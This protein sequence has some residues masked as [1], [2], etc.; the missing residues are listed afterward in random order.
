LEPLFRA[1]LGGSLPARIEFWDGSALG[2]ADA[3]GRARFHSV[4]GI[5][6]IL[7]SPDELG[8]GRAVVVGDVD[9]EG[10]LFA[11]LDTLEALNLEDIRIGPRTLSAAVAAA[12]R[13]GALGWPPAPPPEETRARG[14]RHS[15]A[16]DSRAV[17]HH[18]DVGNDFYRLVLGPSLT[19]SCARYVTEDMT[20][21]QAQSA[22]HEL[23]CA[24]LG[25][26][27]RPGMRL[28]DVGCGWGSMALHA[29]THH[30]ATVVGLTLSE[31]QAELARDRVAERNLTDRVDIRV[32]DYRDLGDEA[33]DAI[34]SIG[35]FE[36][37]GNRNADQYFRILRAR[38][39]PKGRFLNHAISIPGGYALGRRSFAYRYVFPDG[40]LA[41]VGDVI[42]GMER[43]G[44]EVRDVES[45][46]EHYRTTLRRWV[47]N[48][49]SHWDEAVAQVGPARAR[50]WRLYMAGSAVNFDRG[51]LSV[52]QVLGVAADAGGASGMPASRNGWS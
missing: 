31:A 25:L 33:F 17:R 34:S 18:Y 35:M 30:G 23:V 48:L 36:H 42:L 27:E 43:A 51:V 50:I 1:I 29:A 3:A 39:R 44:F 41:D 13:V 20:L 38:L 12:W 6:R 8:L 14:R 2:P 21:E 24:K 5:R 37:V 9:I 49:D 15:K 19:Y 16:R 45:L 52:H 46:R 7:W 47:A 28:L 22:K 4:D 32:Q 26:R 40:E 11:V 10:D